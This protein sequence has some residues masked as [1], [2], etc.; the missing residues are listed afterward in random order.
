[1]KDKTNL[2]ASSLFNG[3]TIKLYNSS[4]F[5]ITNLYFKLNS[6]KIDFASLYDWNSYTFSKKSL[7]DTSSNPISIGSSIISF[8]FDSILVLSILE[9]DTDSVG[10]ESIVS[11]KL[12]QF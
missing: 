5:W 9:I 12:N 11:L 3:P 7:S 2:L 6:V 8:L 10:A 1:M 4:S